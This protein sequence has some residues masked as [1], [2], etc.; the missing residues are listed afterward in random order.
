MFSLVQAIIAA[1]A[2]LIANAMAIVA[3][4]N[5]P[6]I[7][8]IVFSPSAAECRF[9]NDNQSARFRRGSDQAR[10]WP[11]AHRGMHVKVDVPA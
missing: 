8:F 3:V 4:A 10:A 6:F 7:V 2:G 1:D 11:P 5:R 9:D